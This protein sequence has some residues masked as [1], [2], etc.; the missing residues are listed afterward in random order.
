M[1]EK[2]NSSA[3]MRM[4]GS[5]L[6]LW[7]TRARCSREQLADE[8]GYALE[9]VAS[10]EK[11]RRM[12]AP[13][14]VETAE[15]LFDAGGMLRDAA[16][17]IVRSKYPDWFEEYAQYE[18]EAA[19]LDVYENRVFPGLLQ[20]E[21]YARAVFESNWPPLDDE[22]IERRIEARL[23][24][25][26]VLARKPPLAMSVIVEQALLQ[27]CFG[28]VET[29]RGQIQRLL[30]CSE[31]RTLTL[32]VMPTERVPTGATAG[33]MYLLETAECQ[34]V[35]YFEGPRGSFLIT[36]PSDVSEL[37]QAYGIL[38]AQ[39]L[40]PEESAGLLKQRLGDL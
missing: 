9:T 6:R 39:A 12:P 17:K 24:R 36:N 26:A 29:M 15:T 18:A 3:T 33:P 7:R 20:T 38:R 11:G 30:E 5:Q 28:G 1:A 37:N 19:S 35:A 40:S 14:L 31:R 13:D 21:A 34:R 25:Q 32:Q 2:D 22:E 16:S 10:V 4:F 27:R 8:A 23:E